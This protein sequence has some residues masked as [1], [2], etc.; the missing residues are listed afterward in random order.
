MQHHTLGPKITKSKVLHESVFARSDYKNHWT[1]THINACTVHRKLKQPNSNN[2]TDHHLMLSTDKC[3]TVPPGHT[4]RSDGNN[5]SARNSHIPPKYYKGLLELTSTIPTYT[6]GPSSMYRSP[7]AWSPL[8]V[9]VGLG[10]V[11][12][13]QG[14]LL[15]LQATVAWHGIPFLFNV[16]LISP[17]SK[18]HTDA[19]LQSVL[20]P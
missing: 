9:A 7:S 4:P 1:L 12:G 13:W 5:K 15:L 18:N 16:I 3:L 10:S 17:F 2:H 20:V 14:G 6:H 11:G 19:F 8:S